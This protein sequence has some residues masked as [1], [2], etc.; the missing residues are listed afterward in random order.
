MEYGGLKVDDV[1]WVLEEA[2]SAREVNVK[3]KTGM[4]ITIYSKR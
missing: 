3:R 4:I 1:G 2:R